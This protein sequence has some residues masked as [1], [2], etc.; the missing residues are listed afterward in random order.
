MSENTFEDNF[1]D[2]NIMVIS[3]IDWDIRYDRIGKYMSNPN[4][5]KHTSRRVFDEGIK[6]F[7][8]IRRT[9]SQY[10]ENLFRKFK[11]EKLSYDET[12]IN[13]FN[14]KCLNNLDKKEKKILELFIDHYSTEIK[15]KV[16]IGNKKD[17]EDF[18]MKISKQIY[19]L[20]KSLTIDCQDGVS[21]LIFRHDN[22]PWFYNSIY[23]NEYQ[24]LYEVIGYM[25]DVLALLDAY[26]IKNNDGFK[27]NLFFVTL[28]KE[29][30]LGL[31][32]KD[33]IEDIL[34]GISCKSPY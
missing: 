9:I 24:E 4:I 19:S 21:S 27:N 28:D 11:T 32:N 22:C 17:A 16:I 10:I 26:F 31:S 1:L 3:K 33:I 29:H 23:I 14:M 25:E 13:S 34:K 12:K 18:K 15:N 8:R 5:R 7:E 2:A 6:V 20:A 30:I